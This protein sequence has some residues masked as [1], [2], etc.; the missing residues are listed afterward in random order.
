M[1]VTATCASLNRAGHI[2]GTWHTTTLWKYVGYDVCT[3]E[4]PGTFAVNVPSDYIQGTRLECS[5]GFGSHGCH[6]TQIDTGG[7][8]RVDKCYGAR[9][10]AR[11][12]AYMT[13]STW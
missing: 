1:N 6:N 5:G 2:S 12:N 11:G 8:G 10:Q 13:I 9:Y 3:F 4:H 7:S